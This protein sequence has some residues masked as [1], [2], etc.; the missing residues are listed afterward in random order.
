M[1]ESRSELGFDASYQTDFHWG[2]QNP[3][4]KQDYQQSC[5]SM[6]Y[7]QQYQNYYSQWGF[8]P[9]CGYSYG[10]MPYSS[11]Q[12]TTATFPSKAAAIPDSMGTLAETE[13]T[14]T[15]DETDEE[16]VEDPQHQLDVDQMNREFMGRSEELYDSLMNCHWQPLDTVTSEIPTAV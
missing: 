12:P 6:Q 15:T 4:I 5:N 9:Y 8:D 1:G 11:T 13:V 7:Y 3:K 16:L 14:T 2:W 10:Y